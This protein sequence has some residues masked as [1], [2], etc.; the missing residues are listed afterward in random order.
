[1]G[2]SL[3]SITKSFGGS[4]GS[5][6]GGLIGGPAGA[7]VGG[8]I[9]NSL[10]DYSA[11]SM[12]QDAATQ[13]YNRNIALW[14]MNNQYNSPVEQ[15]KRLR[16]AGLNPNLVYGNGSVV[17]NT[18]GQAAGATPYGVTKN[19][20]QSLVD[21]LAQTQVLESNEVNI[22]NKKAETANIIRQNELLA[23]QIDK[24]YAE[25]GNL[26]QQ[27][28]ALTRENDFY[29]SLGKLFSPAGSSAGS[30]LVAGAAP[31]VVKGIGR[32]ASYA[33]RFTPLGRLAN[34]VFR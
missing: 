21:E 8:M 9:G 22:E 15:M 14:N 33:L 27:G 18:S 25:I 17:G 7:A 10:S 4:L 29:D 30:K 23:A 34:Y 31:G 19:S 16:E 24:I 20:R 26:G 28:I 6:A 3:K 12:A 13:A 5:I 1:M 11:N 32:A 2:F